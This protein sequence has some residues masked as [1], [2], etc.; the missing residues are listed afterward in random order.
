MILVSFSICYPV[1]GDSTT[2]YYDY[3]PAEIYGDWNPT[4]NRAI[5]YSYNSVYRCDL[6]FEFTGVTQSADS[7]WINLDSFISVVIASIPIF[8][9]AVSFWAKGFD[10]AVGGIVA[11][12]YLTQTAML[13]F[14]FQVALSLG[15][16]YLGISGRISDDASLKEQRLN[17]SVALYMFSI[18]IFLIWVSGAFYFT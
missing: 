7:Y 5:E 8:L 15:A 10:V 16:L 2:N 17:Y 4:Y 14:V 13:F 18:V 11:T 9:V 1:S 12:Y 3:S 6:V